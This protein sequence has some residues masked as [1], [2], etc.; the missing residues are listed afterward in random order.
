[1]LG[2]LARV[3][4]KE[5][6]AVQ[7]A[8]VPPIMR[9]EARD[10][11]ED[12]R[13]RPLR[14]GEHMPAGEDVVLHAE[15]GSGKTLVYLLPLM[16]SLQAEGPSHSS[17]VRGIIVVPTR[18]LAVQ[19]QREA[20]KLAQRGAKRAKQKGQAPI[21]VRRL[22]GQV[23]DRMLASL[24]R[25]PPHV[26]VAT[27]QTL[28]DLIPDRMQLGA[29]RYLICDEV[30]FLLSVATKPATEYVLAAAARLTHKPR[31]ML[32]SATPSHDVMEAQKA[33]LRKPRLIDL[34]HGSSAMP[35]TITHYIVECVRDN[36]KHNMVT[37]TLS[38]LKPLGTLAFLASGANAE[39]LSEFLASRNVPAATL[40]NATQNKARAKA[41]EQLA[42]GRLQVLM[43][44]EM[45]SRGLDLP[46]VSHVINVDVPA[47][48]RAYVHRAGRVGRM[49]RPGTVVTLATRDEMAD[50]RRVAKAA[51][52][53]V[54]MLRF[55]HGEPVVE[56]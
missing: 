2:K 50:A 3:G 6:S 22:V 45:A 5:P 9:G 15:T 29:L 40:V 18:E 46:R 38:S 14:R 48:A 19:V 55:E 56:G 28:C 27:P 51:G 35:D 33:Y 49:G 17:Q 1:M 44:T 54:K 13:P 7:I 20:E 53:D 32:V 12:G 26:V 30:D 16:A 21:V 42:A 43:S 24:K 23:D 25:D 8:A 47:S 4:F 34:T 36:Q 11:L 52:A 31:M 37:R 39:N 41:L 10:R